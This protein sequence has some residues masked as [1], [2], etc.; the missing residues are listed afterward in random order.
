MRRDLSGARI[1][2]T[3]ASSGIGHALA[4]ELSRYQPRFLLTARRQDRLEEL[5]KQLQSRNC[6]DVT[7]VAGDIT[8]EATRAELMTIIETSFGGLDVLVNNAG[9]GAYGPFAT[10]SASRLQQ[11]MEVNFLA[12]AELTRVSL[13]WL[14]QGT[15]P[16]IVNV[17]SVL[18]HF[19]VPNKSEYCA[20]KFAMHGFSDALRCELARESIDVLLVSPSTTSSEFFQ[21]LVEQEGDPRV[22]SLQMT[23]RTV[24]RKIVA[25][26]R[27][28][29]REIILSWSG[30][31]LVLLDRLAPW[32]TSWIFSQYAPRDADGSDG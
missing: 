25:G 31:L 6:T 32:L 22:S 29:R 1:L 9:V 14:R 16:M 28:G 26:M 13:K 17:G 24:A 3:G 11:L 12:P 15:R 4:L 7:W 20:T 2:I 10:A 19:A 21:Q 18:G 27:A 23:P 30:K 8:E 5:A